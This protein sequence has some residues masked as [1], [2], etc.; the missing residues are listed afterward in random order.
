MSE[1]IM[2]CNANAY[3]YGFENIFYESI[4]KAYRDCTSVRICGKYVFINDEKSRG[5]TDMV[6]N[7]VHRNS[8]IEIYDMIDYM[9]DEYGIEISKSKLINRIRGANVFYSDT[10]EKLYANYDCFFEEV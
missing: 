5:I 6:E 3:D 2:S 1:W 9:R 8:S 10:M 7:I 4:L